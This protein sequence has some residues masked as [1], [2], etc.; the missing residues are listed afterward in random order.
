MNEE[1]VDLQDFIKKTLEKI[2]SATPEKFTIQGPIEFELSVLT[3]KDKTGNVSVRI[4]GLE[5]LADLNS[6]KK[7][8]S[9]QKLKFTIYNKKDVNLQRILSEK[10]LNDNKALRELSV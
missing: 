7:V 3:A 1:D 10:H 4:P 9:T 6:S 5:K 2:D 8:E